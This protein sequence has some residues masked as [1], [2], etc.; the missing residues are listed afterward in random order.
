[1]KEDKAERILRETSVMVL[2]G[3]PAEVEAAMCEAMRALSDVQ[4]YRALGTV[5]EFKKLIQRATPV[6]VVPYASSYDPSDQ[7]IID[8]PSCKQTYWSED[9]GTLNFCPNCG[10]A[11]KVKEADHE[12][13]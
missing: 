5:P 11:F 4:R 13:K 6:E 10:Q 7:Q 2:K 3:K 9:W 8:C 1:M 12:N